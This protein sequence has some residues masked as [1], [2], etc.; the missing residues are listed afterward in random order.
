MQKDTQA[1]Q[2]EFEK[3]LP[4]MPFLPTEMGKHLQE[5]IPFMGQAQGE[6]GG[7]QSQQAIPP[8]QQALD[9]FAQAQNGYSKPCS[10]WRNVAR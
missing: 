9:A 1:L 10:R 7:Q 3:L 4:L 2:Q 5:A 8:E 6:L